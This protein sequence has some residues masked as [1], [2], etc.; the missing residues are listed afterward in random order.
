M[1]NFIEIGGPLPTNLFFKI[2][3]LIFKI[4]AHLNCTHVILCYFL[5]CIIQPLVIN[6]EFER[7]QISM[8]S[9]IARSGQG[10]TRAAAF[11]VVALDRR[12]NAVSSTPENTHQLNQTKNSLF[13]L[14]VTKNSNSDEYKKYT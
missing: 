2:K 8:V 11:G 9:V 10:A 12:R 3:T 13:E 6:F 5:A 1:P 7:L 14:V 4:R